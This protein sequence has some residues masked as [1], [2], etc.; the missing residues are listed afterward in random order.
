MHS[1]H[2]GGVSEGSRWLSAKRDT[3]GW[4]A[5]P[6]APRQGCRK[7]PPIRHPCRGASVCA[8]Q[9]VVSRFALNHR[10]PSATP[11]ALTLAGYR[12]TRR[13]FP[14]LFVRS[15]PRVSYRRRDLRICKDVGQVRRQISPGVATSRPS[16]PTVVARHKV[17]HFT[18][19][20][21]RGVDRDRA[22]AAMWRTRGSARV[23]L[24]HPFT[25]Q[26]RKMR[27]A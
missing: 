4:D 26:R 24:G 20:M 1:I 17:R 10:L 11:P 15:F 12:G 22:R 18:A 13:S 2:A 16:L 6:I 25:A 19:S 7:T 9:P 8:A 21:L 3:T 5:P 14:S 27:H 23:T